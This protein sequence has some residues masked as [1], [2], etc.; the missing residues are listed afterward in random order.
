MPQ[1]PEIDEQSGSILF[2]KNQIK[3]TEPENT[4][5]HPSIYIQKTQKGQFQTLLW[6]LAI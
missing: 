5:T 3:K 6:T 2:D 4:I 1:I